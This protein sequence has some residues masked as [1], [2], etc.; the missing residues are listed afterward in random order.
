MYHTRQ[1]IRLK[2]DIKKRKKRKK[3]H[4]SV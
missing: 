1:R 4:K 3:K 2:D